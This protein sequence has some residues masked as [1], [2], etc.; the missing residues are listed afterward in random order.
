[1]VVSMVAVGEESGTLTDVL[2]EISTF[3]RAK[4]EVLVHRVTG[5]MEPIIVIFMGVAV[6]GILMS[7]Y[8]PMFQMAGGPANCSAAYSGPS[9][10][11]GARVSLQRTFRYACVRRYRARLASGHLRG[12]GDRRRW[13]L[14]G[15]HGFGIPLATSC[16]AFGS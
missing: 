11:L 3:Y 7:I 13:T 4:V 6:G 16:C 14:A 2:H 9:A 10:A 12:L 1:M 8:L 5:M 15:S